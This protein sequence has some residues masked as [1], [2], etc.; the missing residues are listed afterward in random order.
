M[1]TE[2][3]GSGVGEFDTPGVPQTPGIFARKAT[4]LVREVSPFSTFAFN[5]SVAPTAIF[6][7]VG[8]FGALVTWPGGNLYLGL[9]FALIFALAFAIAFGLAASAIPRSGGDYIFVSRVFHPALGLMSSFFWVVTIALSVAYYGLGFT[10]VVLSPSFSALGVISNS[11]T[12]TSWGSTLATSKGWQFAVGAIVILLGCAILAV[13]WKWATRYVRYLWFVTLIS[14]AVA[15][16]FLLVVGHSTL[17]NNYNQVALKAGGPP[18]AYHALLTT[19]AH[20]KVALNPGF[21][22]AQTLPTA[23]FI[24]ALSVWTWMSI[25]IAG[26]VRRARS[27]THTAMMSAPAVLHILIGV[28]AVVVFFH[29]FGKEFMTAAGASIGAKAYPFPNTSYLILTSAAG[30]SP[31]LA[32]FLFITFAVAFPLV[33]LTNTVTLIRPL[34]A[35]AFDGIIP[36]RVARVSRRGHQPIVA[37]V[38]CAILCLG[39]MVWAVWGGSSFFGVLAEANLFGMTTMALLSAAV[40]LLPFRHPEAWRASAT[41][42]TVLGIPLLSLFGCFA[43]AC[44]I[45]FYIAYL[46]YPT[47]GIDGGKFGRDIG[48]VSG[49]ALLTYTVGRLTASR[50]GIDVQKL[51]TEIPP[52]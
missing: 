25:F 6:V 45:A 37:I 46:H 44:A 5:I 3:V 43:L 7:A 39:A 29:V 18:N 48:I 10:T 35:W 20:N 50:R 1:S 31:A 34:F 47:L 36:M 51:S 21:S 14:M 22:F 27:L 49:A 41:T 30:N 19:A 17:V 16:I 40:I 9:L 42:R 15:F 32:W 23:A 13:G 11:S 28:I 38:L 33:I 8:I 26:E 12:L 4:G 24:M 52:E 2:Q